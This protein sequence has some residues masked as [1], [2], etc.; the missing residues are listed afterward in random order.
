[1]A[2]FL[3]NSETEVRELYG[4]LKKQNVFVNNQEHI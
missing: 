1:M 3:F 2:R 4:V